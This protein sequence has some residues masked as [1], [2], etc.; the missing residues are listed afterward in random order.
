MG[1]PKVPLISK[2][3]TLETALRIIDEE[4]LEE[5]SIRRLAREL[6]INGASLYH[7]FRNKEDILLGS[8]QLALE[9]AR[10]LESPGANWRDWFIDQAR[11][12][13]RALLDHPAL[14]TVILKQHPHRI[15]LEFYDKAVR[16]LLQ[17]GVPRP[18]IIPLIESMESFTFGSVLYTTAAQSDTGE[19]DETFEALNEARL[20]AVAHVDDEQLWES[21][22]RSITDAVLAAG[23]TRLVAEETRPAT[24]QR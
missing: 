19:I 21:V 17:S 2:R 22:A 24:V 1:R 18:A 20:A 12:Y 6:D 16:I 4:G 7:H 11:L 10:L 13:R 5:L 3:A 23:W 8:A 14:V 15:A 9:D